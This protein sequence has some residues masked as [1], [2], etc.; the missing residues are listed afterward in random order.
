MSFDNATLDFDP[1][2][3]TPLMSGQPTTSAY[4][5]AKNRLFK[6]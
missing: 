1:D 6:L 3:S 4:V 2:E 5:I